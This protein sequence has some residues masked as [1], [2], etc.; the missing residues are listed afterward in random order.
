MQIHKLF[1]VL[2]T[3]PLLAGTSVQSQEKLSGK[4]LFNAVASPSCG[5][6][7]TLSDAG[8][9]GKVGP[10]LDELKPSREKVS[11]AVRTGVGAMPSYSE[12]LSEE[13]ISILARYVANVAGK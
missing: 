12:D 5:I 10:N 1:L 2:L 3:A 11:T 13:Q 4:H 6:C 8:A 7:H 9:S